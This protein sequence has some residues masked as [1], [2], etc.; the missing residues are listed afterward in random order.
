M[1]KVPPLRDRKGIVEEVA[2]SLA[3]PGG[4]RLYHLLSSTYYWPGMR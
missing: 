4:S 1:R 3:Y 2:R